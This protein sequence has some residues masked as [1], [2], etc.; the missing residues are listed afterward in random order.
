MDTVTVPSYTNMNTV[1]YKEHI[2]TTVAFVYLRY[3]KDIVYLSR[4]MKC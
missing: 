2:Y 3:I 4:K 1:K